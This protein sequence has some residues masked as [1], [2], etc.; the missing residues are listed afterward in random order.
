[1]DAATLEHAL[2]MLGQILKD[3]GFHYE[4]VAIGG[5]S[6]LLLGQVVRTTKDLDLVALVESDHFISANPLPSNLL[7]ARDEVAIAL[8]LGED[9]LNPGPTSL[10]NSGLPEGFKTRMQ[11][12]SYGGLTVHFSG[13]FDQICFKLYA[14][15]DHGPNS[16]HFKDLKLLLPTAE[17]LQKAK[18]WCI[19]HDVSEGFA[20]TLDEAIF[21]LGAESANA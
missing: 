4:V 18:S 10:L 20:L 13:R 8:E 3:R 1:M 17:E 21:V 2:D 9:W 14:S 19:T 6:L 7:K 15:I 16:K 12:R 11:T 5:G